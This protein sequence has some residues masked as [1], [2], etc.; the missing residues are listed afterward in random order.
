MLNI[1]L[2]PREIKDKIAQARYSANVFSIC[3]VA[4]FLVI[5]LGILAM[6]AN[7]MV[8]EPGLATVKEDI[9]QNANELA[10]FTKLENKALFLNDRAKVSL[11]IEQKR[12][13]WSQ[14]VQNLINSV[15]QEVQFSSLTVDV[16]KSPNFVVSGYAKNERDIISFKDKLEASEFFKNVAFKSAS[17]ENTPVQTTPLPATAPTDGTQPI[18]AAPTEKR[19][20]FSLEF[21]LEKYFLTS[22]G[23]K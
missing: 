8:L 20:S 12:P 10:A 3:L 15:P 17:A 5:V 16:S 1:N 22:A 19:V 13:L 7:T 11:E 21:D 6:A 2:V 23:T 18:T 9:G 4:V 14:I